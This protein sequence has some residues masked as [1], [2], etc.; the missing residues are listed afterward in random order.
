MP[1]GRTAR[2]AS[3]DIDGNLFIG[4]WS[5][6]HTVR[7]IFCRTHCRDVACW[8]SCATLRRLSVLVVRRGR[9]ISGI[10]RVAG[11]DAIGWRGCSI[12]TLGPAIDCDS[13]GFDTI[14]CCSGV[15]RCCVGGHTRGG[16][17]TS[18]ADSSPGWHF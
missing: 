17:A 1:A 16:S 12:S 10:G 11:C 4:S 13:I 5:R 14:R 6:R 3:C 2:I 8:T 18:D 7:V 15:F 9:R